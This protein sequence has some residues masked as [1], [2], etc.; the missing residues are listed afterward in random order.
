MIPEE[1]H[2]MILIALFA[3]GIKFADKI[4]SESKGFEFAM[5]LLTYGGML[6]MLIRYVLILAKL[7][8]A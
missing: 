8:F 2:T 5:A 7:I 4:C 1:I 3:M 6:A